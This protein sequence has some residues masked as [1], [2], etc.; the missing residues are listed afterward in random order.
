MDQPFKKFKEQEMIISSRMSIDEDTL[1][2][3]KRFNYYSIINFY[4]APFLEKNKNLRGKDK[5]IEN[6]KFKYLKSLHDFD[7]ELRILFFDNLT[8]LESFFKT[9]ISYYFSETN[10]ILKKIRIFF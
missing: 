9:A 6:F 10:G 1:S 8:L 3:L 7:R 4:K 2:V 5:Y